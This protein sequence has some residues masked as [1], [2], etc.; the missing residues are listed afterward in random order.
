[1]ITDLINKFSALP[2]A[3]QVSYIIIFV[4]ICLFAL[5][6]LGY[7]SGWLAATIQ[8]AGDVI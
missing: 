3:S 8:I 7:F 4:I 6:G 2:T 1:M 5:Y